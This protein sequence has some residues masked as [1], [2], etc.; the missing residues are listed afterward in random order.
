MNDFH[1]IKDILLLTLLS[2]PPS[3]LFAI[4]DLWLALKIRI[5]DNQKSNFLAV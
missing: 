1:K 2:S 4:T 3:P 5:F